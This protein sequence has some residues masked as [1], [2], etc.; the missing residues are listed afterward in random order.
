MKNY[1]VNKATE[2]TRKQISV[3][4]YKAKNQELKIEKWIMSDFYEMADYYGFDDNNTVADSERRI[5]AILDA[6]F[7]KDLE[8]A[9]EL[10]NDYTEYTWNGL[11]NK[12]KKSANRSLVA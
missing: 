7:A 8:K 3:L 2:F 12:S 10:I 11:S 6:V 5:L 1:G 9:Q 4:Y